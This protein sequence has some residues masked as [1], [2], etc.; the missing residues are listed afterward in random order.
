MADKQMLIEWKQ[1]SG[2]MALVEELNR[3]RKELA[4]QWEEGGFTGET[5]DRTMQLNSRA[6]GR[7][8]GF[9]DIMDYIDSISEDNND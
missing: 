7:S 1:H 6:L 5:A 8:Q 2:T 9:S 4:L 3:L